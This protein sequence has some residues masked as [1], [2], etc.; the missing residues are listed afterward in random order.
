M[1]KITF[2]LFLLPFIALSQ[3]VTQPV[4]PDMETSYENYELLIIAIAGLAVLLLIYFYF[5]RTRR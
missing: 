4:Q 1:K 5:K 2:L 3:T